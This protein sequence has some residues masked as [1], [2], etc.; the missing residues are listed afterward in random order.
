MIPTP[1]PPVPPEVP[2]F[3]PGRPATS[4]KGDFG[5]VLI[6]AGS[7]GMHG[8][9]ALCAG[10]AFR[11]GAGLV[12][13]ALPASIYPIVGAL[14]PRATY[15]PLPEQSPGV[16]QPEAL[17]VLERALG[18]ND[19]VAV[20]PGLGTHPETRELLRRWVPQIDR[21]LV[22]D[23]DGLNAFAGDPTALAGPNRT[24]VLTPHPGELERL[25]GARSDRDDDS[26]RVA[27]IDLAIRVAGIVVLKG[28]RSVVTDGL[29][30]H[31]NPTGNPGMATG[32]AGDVLTGALAALLCVIDRPLR[33]ARAATWA[34]GRAGDLAR[35]RRGEAGLTA[36]DMLEE[37]PQAVAE[38]VETEPEARGS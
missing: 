17:E 32:G 5:K 3:V 2:R 9:A 14:E 19:V 31:F 1:P 6:F 18:D 25:S 33:A 34:H 35:E 20:G 11:S 26:R 36:T 15:L 27:S 16:L 8:A 23:A 37:L 30:V 22:V 24:T 10:A 21:P 13:V 4:H 29:E 12:R 38:L 7:W 28:H